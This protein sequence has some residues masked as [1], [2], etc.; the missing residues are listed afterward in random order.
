MI[1][2]SFFQGIV[3]DIRAVLSEEI[4]ADARREAIGLIALRIIGALTIVLSTGLFIGGTISLCTASFGAIPTVILAIA[5][6]ILGYDCAVIAH[7]RSE[8]RK[9]VPQEHSRGI[10][11][12]FWN[13]LPSVVTGTSSDTTPLHLRNTAVAAP[14]YVWLSN[15]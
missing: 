7:N 11:G 3:S 1:I 8:L 4:K 9:T 5:G 12:Y 10:S 13:M 14:L 6:A 15:A 2:G